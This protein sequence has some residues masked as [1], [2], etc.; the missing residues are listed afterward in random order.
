MK[1]LVI[2]HLSLDKSLTYTAENVDRKYKS[3]TEAIKQQLKEAINSELSSRSDI[4]HT[5][6]DNSLDIS[7][8]QIV[9]MFNIRIS[10]QNSSKRINGIYSFT[11]NFKKEVPTPTAID[12]HLGETFS[13]SSIDN[14]PFRTTDNKSLKYYVD[15]ID[16]KNQNPEIITTQLDAKI[17]EVLR[18]KSGIKFELGNAN[19]INIGS[20][21]T[22][23]FPITITAQ[24]DDENGETGT[25]VFTIV[26]TGTPPLALSFYLGPNFTIE[27]IFSKYF[28]TNDD[29]SLIYNIDDIAKGTIDNNT[30]E[31]EFK[32]AIKD[33]LDKNIDIIH[34]LGES[35]KT[36]TDKQIDVQIPVT[37]TRKN[38]SKSSIE[39]IYIFTIKYETVP[40]IVLDFDLGDNFTIQGLDGANFISYDAESLVYTASN[41][42]SVGKNG[43]TLRDEIK[44]ALTATLDN[45]TGVTYKYGASAYYY[46]N[47]RPGGYLE[48]EYTIIM[49]Q[50]NKPT[51]SKTKIYKFT[52]NFNHDT[53]IP[54]KPTTPDFDLGDNFTIPEFG[55]K[56]FVSNDELSLIYTIDNVTPF[57]AHTIYSGL[58]REMRKQ[59]DKNKNLG[60]VLDQYLHDYS[61]EAGY[62]KT[63]TQEYE[64]EII[65]LHNPSNKING[66]YSFTM[67]FKEYVAPFK[68]N[69]D[70]GDSFT[71]PSLNGTV[72]KPRNGILNYLART[73]ADDKDKIVMM[74]ELV[75]AL[76]EL[77]SK[78]DKVDHAIGTPTTTGEIGALRQLNIRIPVTLTD[79]TNSDNISI[80][81][82]EFSFPFINDVWDGSSSTEPATSADN[83]YLVAHATDLAWLAKQSSIDKNIR[84]IANINMDNKTFTGIKEFK[85]IFDGDNH[86]I[87]KLNIVTGTDTTAL[88]QK[89]TGDSIIKNIVLDIG[90]INGTK[91]TSGLI[92]TA[93]GTSADPLQLEISNSTSNLKIFAGSENADYEMRLGGFLAYAKNVDLTVTNLANHGRIDS[94]FGNYC[95]IGGLIGQVDSDTGRG[96]LTIKG[97]K[98][99]GQMEIIDCRIRNYIGG[100]VGYNYNRKTYLS[101]ISNRALVHTNTYDRN[102]QHTHLGGLIGYNKNSVPSNSSDDN[103][104][105]ITSTYN[106]RSIINFGE[107][108][109]IVGGFIG[110]NISPKTTINYSHNTG[111]IVAD[112]NNSATLGGLIGVNRSYNTTLVAVSNKGA[113]NFGGS[114]MNVTAGGLIGVN[115]LREDDQTHSEIS[116]KTAY[117]MGEIKG[118]NHTGGLIGY[119]KADNTTITA[120]SNRHRIGNKFSS[121]GGIIGT[122]IS[123][124]SITDTYNIGGVS[125]NLYIGGLVGESR[126]NHIAI[127]TSYNTGMIQDNINLYD[128][129]RF[130]GGIIGYVNLLDN[131]TASPNT[132]TVE[133]THNKGTIAGGSDYYDH[134]QILGRIKGD[135]INTYKLNYYST[136]HPIPEIPPIESFSYSGNP[137]YDGFYDMGSLFRGWDFKEVWIIKKYRDDGHPVLR[138]N[139][140]APFH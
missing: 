78:N 81:K 80:G 43:E 33:E 116:I 21:I 2:N 40:S 37:I 68:P 114:S 55:N 60:Y 70:I 41:I 115:S 22:I 65:E 3:N 124:I 119:N 99:T 127:K 38:N 64:I 89:I 27:S 111:E 16:K 128:E 46:N 49:T 71:I 74:N 14:E 96:T 15:E 6:G 85:G 101:N 120:C 105:T 52:I 122:N 138:I 48:V 56:K 4:A 125:G 92:G 95:Y 50:N 97:S 61:G 94:N 67:K 19:T 98:N 72:F 25:Y 121:S 126:S 51:N 23:E 108:S 103:G 10:D 88:I 104:V 42:N 134:D 135:S 39:G 91:Y 84:V 66:I 137:I 53:T 45:K 87:K 1:I 7:D 54:P 83:Y 109:S 123:D 9:V 20:T 5:L 136:S 140:E 34:T 139:K 35:S 82:Y 110:E 76:S 17:R 18:E 113:T 130:G 90:T 79:K 57:Y 112:T 73:T 31:A 26:F 131:D 11:I 28:I 36:I 69:F 63:L 24:N 58:Q 100:L 44:A 62:G 59:L 107:H 32:K 132:L 13:I 8:N 118:A 133:Q 106:T 47:V 77:H 86:S 102:H 30:V 93:T 129:N 75:A 117:N 12:F 29:N